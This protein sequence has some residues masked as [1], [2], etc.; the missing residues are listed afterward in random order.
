MIFIYDLQT[1][2]YSETFSN[3]EWIKKD[4]I[5]SRS[6]CYGYFSK[7]PIPI[8]TVICREDVIDELFDTGLSTHKTLYTLMTKYCEKFSLLA[9]REYEKT[10][11]DYTNML[12]GYVNSKMLDYFTSMG[13]EDFKLNSSKYFRNRFG[14]ID[15]HIAGSVLLFESSGFNHSCTPNIDYFITEDSNYKLTM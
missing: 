1:Y 13:I 12:N 3:S 4:R 6:N 2:Y 9:P 15:N 14:F 8:G 7:K 5:A 11:K 10:N